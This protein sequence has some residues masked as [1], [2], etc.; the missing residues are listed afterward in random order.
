[1]LTK[2]KIT[3]DVIWNVGKIVLTDC[4]VSTECGQEKLTNWGNN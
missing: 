3:K 4:S 2:I 1:M